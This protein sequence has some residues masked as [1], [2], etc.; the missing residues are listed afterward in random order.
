[1][2]LLKNIL[3]AVAFTA[4]GAAFAQQ[5]MTNMSTAELFGTDVDDF[6]DVNEYHNVQ[7]ENVFAYLSYGKD[8]T[9]NK[10]NIGAAHQFKNFYLGGWFG[11]QLNSWSSTTS[12]DKDKKATLTN[13]HSTDTL[14]NGKLLFGINNMGILADVKFTPKT[15][16]KYLNNGTTKKEETYNMFNLVTDLKFGINLNG[17]NDRVY[18]NWVLLGLDSNVDRK[19][20]KTDGKIANS[21]DK[22]D[23][24]TYKLKLGAGTTFDFLEKDAVTHTVGMGLNTSWN[25]H[26]GQT[27]EKV[28]NR[29]QFEGVMA[30]DPNWTITYEPNSRFAL[31]TKV[32]LTGNIDFG[33]G[34]DYTDNNG[35]KTYSNRTYTTKLDF[36]PSLA[37]GATYKV[38]P[39]KFSFNAGFAFNVPKF[40]WIFSKTDNRNSS[41]GSVES[42]TSSVNFHF[43]SATGKA[44]SY[45]GFTWIPIKNVTVDANWNLFGDLFETGRLGSKIDGQ[46]GSVWD[47]V[48]KLLFHKFAFIVSVK[49]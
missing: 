19:V 33:V 24:S 3:L 45:S 47:N 8:A 32:G 39:E 21:T 26:V 14:A 6:M 38:L 49:L 46:S 20:I 35:T 37:L 2:K 17:K 18:K 30:L 29:G 36:V 9:D 10:L 31:K 44:A 43:D 4:A 48:N 42:S 34:I 1:M 23:N 12:F 11:G 15:T 27:G 25:I 40:G 22:T 5:S 16:N 28:Y 13:Q 7:P 41:S